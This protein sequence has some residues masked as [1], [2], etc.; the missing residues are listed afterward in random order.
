MKIG[1]SGYV[2]VR[3]AVELDYSV[4][5]SVCSLIPICDEVVVSDGGSTD[6][7]RELIESIGDSRVRIIDYPWPNPVR[8]I[9]F[10]TTWLNW[11]RERLNYDYQITLDADEI[12][13]PSAYDIIGSLYEDGFC[14]SFRRLNFWGDSKHIA[15]PNRVCGDYVAR[16]GPQHLFACSDEPEVRVHPNLRSK[17][18]RREGL[19]IFHT[20][21]IR[22]PK[23]FIAKSEA[24]QGMF[25]G[26]CDPRLMKFKEIGG[27]W[28]TGNYFD[29]LPL[30]PCAAPWPPVA[31]DWLRSHGYSP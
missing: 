31:H 15:P 26:S 10:L 30:E 23:K 19:T 3:N 13:A 16:C 29:D 2:C 11:T 25:F 5:E 8:D 20:G 1:I 18:E 6:G 22:D 9:H 14:G 27:D 21:F 7:T 24:V 4:K 12:L 28:R 17:A